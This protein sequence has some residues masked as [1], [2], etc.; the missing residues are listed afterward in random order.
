VA[1][2]D[3]ERPLAE[4]P[5]PP[6]QRSAQSLVPTIDAV[7]AQVGWEPRQIE[8][9][10]VTSGPGSFTS[11]RIGVSTAKALAYAAEARIVGINTLEAI[12]R[13][14]AAELAA[15]GN[16]GSTSIAAILDAQR[17]Q[18]FAA[19]FRRTP[20]GQ[21][22][23]QTPTAVIDEHV[24]LDGLTPGDI[25]TGPGLKRLADRLPTGV[26]ALDSGFWSPT[27]AVVGQLG[28]ESF[29][30]GRLDE[31]FQL[32]PQYFRRTAA[33]EQWERLHGPNA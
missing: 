32:V 1:A 8:L 6:H 28:F 31:V 17:E 20:T 25:V 16:V 11:L 29:V 5:L 23:W 30:A 21:F 13:R 2:L 26:V 33:E 9:V 3:D 18:L 4:Q 10:A 22:E 24:W 27:A 19:V 14:A 12:A 15:S 7:L